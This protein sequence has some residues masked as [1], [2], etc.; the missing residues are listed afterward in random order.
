MAVIGLEGAH[1]RAQHGFYEEERI[2]GG[3]YIIDVYLSLDT[4]LAAHADDLYR[5]ANYETVYLILQSEMRKPSQLIEAVAQR[6]IMRLQEHFEKI[7]GIRLRLR[8]LNP[9]M[10]GRVDA[11]VIEMTTGVFAR[12]V[13]GG[14][15]DLTFR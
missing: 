13:G 2:L 1:F 7:Q 8:K 9:P 6:I 5:T 10:G 15:L 12:G 11:A 14:G 4:T 3:D